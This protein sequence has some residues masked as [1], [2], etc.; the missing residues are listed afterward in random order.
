MPRLLQL[1]R[2]ASVFLVGPSTP[3]APL[4]FE[5]GIDTLAGTVVLDPEAVWRAVQEGAAR[6]V[7]DRGAQMVKL[8]HLD[9]AE[10]K[11]ERSGGV[12]G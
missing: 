3:F 6:A 1:S 12:N 8:S 7:F 2:N 9:W 4:L 10:A 5:Y 11:G